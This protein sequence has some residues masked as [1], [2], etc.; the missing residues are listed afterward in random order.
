MGATVSKNTVVDMNKIV[1]DVTTD[2]INTS[3]K[4][5]MASQGSSQEQVI[6]EIRGHVGTISQKSSMSLNMKCVQS[7]INESK[8]Q[9]DI[10]SKLTSKIQQEAKA[11]PTLL[12]ANAAI[13]T[14]VNFT[15]QI[16][17]ISQHVTN[18]NISNCITDI[19]ARQKQTIGLISGS[20]DTLSQEIDLNT[21]I[22]CLMN[23]STV[24]DA[25]ANL[26][27]EVT[28]TTDQKAAAGMDQSTIIIIVIALVIL[29]VVGGLAYLYFQSGGAAAGPEAMMA[30]QAFQAYGA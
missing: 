2:V 6:G 4:S 28:N 16:T 22:E 24:Q 9:N 25:I 3:V 19:T 21:V 30:K 12:N 7:S 13:N 14:N 11:N 20:V 29:A 17:K 18:E 1:N 8:M 23:D 10:A 26:K 27:T 5:C 15:D